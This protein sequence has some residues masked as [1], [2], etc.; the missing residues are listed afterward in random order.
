MSGSSVTKGAKA[1][2]GFCSGRAAPEIDELTVCIKPSEVVGHLW[3]KKKHSGKVLG[4][5]FKPS[6]ASHTLTLTCGTV[7]VAQLYAGS[8]SYTAHSWEQFHPMR[9]VCESE[10]QESAINNESQSP[11][12]SIQDQQDTFRNGKR[13]VTLLR[14][15][16]VRLRLGL[17]LSLRA[18][19]LERFRIIPQRMST[20]PELISL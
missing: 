15:W 2:C 12:I 19:T 18:T 14:V 10:A 16:S 7:Q 20:M 1:V 8:S 6:W 4:L 3:N 13:R 9:K 17:H 5:E 11:R